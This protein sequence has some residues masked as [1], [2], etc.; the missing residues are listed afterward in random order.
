MINVLWEPATGL[1]PNYSFVIHVRLFKPK[2]HL[3]DRSSTHLAY[4]LL[5]VFD[6]PHFL[7]DPVLYPLCLSICLT[8]DYFL[9]ILK[10]S[11]QHKL[12]VK[13]CPDQ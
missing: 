4:K 9:L 2:P 6:P 7:N 8:I 11:Y 3:S 5:V 12:N 10:Y 1:Y 13:K